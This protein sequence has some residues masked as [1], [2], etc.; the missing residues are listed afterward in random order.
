[1]RLDRPESLDQQVQIGL[2]SRSCVLTEFQRQRRTVG[3][4]GPARWT[5]ARLLGRPS[6]RERCTRRRRKLDQRLVILFFDARIKERKAWLRSNDHWRLERHGRGRRG[7][8]RLRHLMRFFD[9]VNAGV[10]A[11][12]P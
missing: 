8:R 2:R 6:H 11:I 7:E 1:M 10:Q 5:K 4:S 12:D 9:M 3:W